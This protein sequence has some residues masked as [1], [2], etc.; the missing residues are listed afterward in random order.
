[1]SAGFH[2][3]SALPQPDTALLSDTG[4]PRAAQAAGEGEALAPCFTDSAVCRRRQR[5]AGCAYW[6]GSPKLCTWGC[7]QHTWGWG[8]CSLEQ[9]TKFAES[10]NSP[11]YNSSPLS[12]CLHVALRPRPRYPRSI[13]SPSRAEDLIW[14]P[15]KPMGNWLWVAA[16]MSP[17]GSR[18]HHQPTV[19]SPPL[20]PR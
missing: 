20:Q 18:G 12:A 17:A 10:L 16:S 2:L 11:I 9:Y 8:F 6:T 15:L 14:H 3:L 13:T 4:P 7:V 19:S 5:A 1:M